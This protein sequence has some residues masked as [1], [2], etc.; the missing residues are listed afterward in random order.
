M[1]FAT[2]RTNSLIIFP[3]WSSFFTGRV[4]SWPSEQLF[5]AYEKSTLY[6]RAQ[7]PKGLLA[8]GIKRA[9]M[10]GLE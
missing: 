9:Y 5:F 4:T 3:D 6:H 2:T 10:Y 1:K 8:L 7:L